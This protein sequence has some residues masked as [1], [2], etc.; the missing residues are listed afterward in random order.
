MMEAKVMKK[1]IKQSTLS[2]FLNSLSIVLILL[3]C[4]SF[5]LITKSNSRVDQAAAARYELY[6]NARRFLDAAA[7]LTNEVRAY[8]ATGN[9]A[10]YGNYWTE[11]NTGKNR[12]IA[13]TRMREI[14]LTY[15]EGALVTEMYALSNNL[16]PL[17]KEAMSLVMVGNTE[18]ALKEVY[19]WSYEDWIARIRS[20]QAKFVTMLDERTEEQ[21]AAERRTARIWTIVNLLCLAVTASI[22]VISTVLVRVKLIRPLMMVRDEM[23]NIERGNL[24]SEFNAT[25]DTSE[26]GM[27]I[28]SMQATKLELNAYIREISEKLAAI[29]NGDSSARIDSNYP[30][31]FM[32]IKNSINEI[33]QILASQREQEALIRKELQIACENAYTASQAKGNFLSNMSHEMRTPMNAILGMTS[34]A[35]SSDD[36]MRREYCLHKINDA[37]N[38]LLGVINDILD[39][40]KIDSGKFEL[41][42]SEF[43]FEKMMIRVVNIVNFRVDEKHQQLKVRLDPHL[44][45][46][47]VSDD[48][49]LAQVITNL[50]SNA[51]KF[52]PEEGE[53][54][55]EVRLLH[56][57]EQACRICVAVS[58]NGI[59]ITA[60]Q[61][62]RLFSPFTQADTGI[63]RKFGGTGLGLAISRSIIEKMDGRIWVEAE[64][65][66]GSTFSFEFRAACGSQSDEQD[67]LLKGINWNTLRV[68]AVDDDPGCLEYFAS[69]AQHFG[70]ACDLAASGSEALASLETGARYDIFFLDWNMPDLNGIDL[71]AKIRNKGMDKAAIVLISSADWS[72]IERVATAAGV[73]SF[74]PKPL[75]KSYILSKIGEC[76]GARPGEEQERE[77]ELPD[78]S[79]KHI[80]LAED[81]EL[82]REIVLALLE[83]TGVSISC[84]ENGAIAFEMFAKNPESFDMIFMD[85]QMPEMDGSTATLK[86]RALE[87][88]W[89]GQVTIVAMTANVFREDVERCLEVGMNDHLGKPLNM[90]EL[91]EKMKRYLRNGK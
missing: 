42:L 2:L 47:L 59:G 66:R 9:I 53:I 70:F 50:L 54:A 10:H 43:N 61:Q 49:R 24:R 28:G 65:G 81:N 38:H 23:L 41:S 90:D 1:A 57:D 80:L 71:A 7:Y 37:S 89:A 51:V 82:N 27:L 21:V 67:S 8:A 77:A 22:Q 44:P 39:M 56:R 17:E 52:T 35:L 33:S 63:A 25:P 58:D 19:G 86:I 29:A 84:A 83:P 5:Y 78:F 79:G 13:V 14:G 75:F 46:S 76:L 12:D 15:H 32:E 62:N 20:A 87:H 31:D 18:G 4:V 36:P 55:I 34:I 3:C 45:V 40:S 73:N 91:I 60:E 69:I 11:V 74:M 72:E 88:P 68:L 30:G 48:Q 64:E 85:M 16:I 26:I 6:H